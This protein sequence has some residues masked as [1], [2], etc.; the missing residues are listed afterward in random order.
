M[1]FKSLFLSL[2]LTISLFSVG[3]TQCGLGLATLTY[4]SIKA[5]GTAISIV[6]S[7]PNPIIPIG[8]PILAAKILVATETIAVSTAAAATVAGPL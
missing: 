6:A 5:V 1:N 2:I 3:S 8:N 4:Y 7:I